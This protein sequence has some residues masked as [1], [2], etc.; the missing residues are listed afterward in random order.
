MKKG[1]GKKDISK[2]DY[3]IALEKFY[4]EEEIQKFSN[5]VDKIEEENLNYKASYELV[6]GMK[7]RDVNACLGMAF[8]NEKN[9]AMVRLFMAE[10]AISKDTLVRMK[11][12]FFDDK[13]NEFFSDFKEEDFFYTQ[14]LIEQDDKYLDDSLKGIYISEIRYLNGEIESAIPDI[15]VFKKS[16]NKLERKKT[17]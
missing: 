11:N 10:R 8:F 12:A 15:K 16:F 13:I 9:N 4:S 14:A 17:L 3:F 5:I 1:I 6:K 7:P 2:K